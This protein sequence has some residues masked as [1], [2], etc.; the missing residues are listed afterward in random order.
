MTASTSYAWYPPSM[1]SNNN[2][3]TSCKPP[4]SRH[5]L[6]FL[7]Y[8]PEFLRQ[9]LH[10]LPGPSWS[11][12]ALFCSSWARIQPKPSPGEMFRKRR[13]RAFRTPGTWSLLVRS[14]T[15]SVK[16]QQRE[17]LGCMQQGPGKKS[18]HDLRLTLGIHCA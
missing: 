9:D 14:S 5:K 10:T 12:M 11:R 2:H 17:R 15:C 6:E 1:L 16:V 7:P 8:M 4:A 13:A 3:Q 18:D